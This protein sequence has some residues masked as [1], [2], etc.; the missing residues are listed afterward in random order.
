MITISKARLSGLC[1]LVAL[2]ALAVG[3]A[4]CRDSEAAPLHGDGVTAV[5]PG[6]GAA[7]AGAPAK[8]EPAKVEPAKAQAAA[9]TAAP[10]LTLSAVG[11]CTLGSDYRVAGAE[12][13]FHL[14]MDRVSNDYSVPF[15]NVLA[16][17]A[18]DDLTIANL[19]TPLSHAKPAVDHPF[20]FN[21]KPEYAE[22]LARGSVEMVNLANNHTGDFGVEGAKQT[23][24]AVEKA[25]VGAFGN[26]RIDRRVVKG[27]EVVN[28]GYLGG[29]KGTRERV[30]KDVKKHKRD[31]NLV[32]VS[33]HWGVEGSNVPVGDQRKMAR[34]VLDAGANLVLGH[35]PHVLQGIETYAGKHIVYSLGNFVFGGHSNPADKD[36]MIYQEVF[37]LED[38]KV[39]SKENRVLPVRISSVTTHNDFQPVLLEGAEKER[40]LGRVKKYSD[41]LLAVKK[42]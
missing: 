39:V 34:A 22:I 29:G 25:G 19:E 6:A 32:I 18:A 17:L 38:G 20:I 10:T 23:L 37:A 4:G 27:I 9:E 28:I 31:D 7:P 26:G 14:A 42:P 12:G 15:A 1:G 24:A 35:H 33:F 13:S 36:S 2:A 5:G 16:V 40:V 30:V 11:D 3:A 8:V 41:M 21:G